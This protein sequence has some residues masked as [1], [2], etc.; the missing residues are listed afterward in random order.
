MKEGSVNLEERLKALQKAYE[1][2][3][4]TI[5]SLPDL[6]P[7]NIKKT[8]KEGVLGDTNLKEFIEDIKNH[9][10]PRFMLIGRTGVGKSSMINALCQSYTAPVSDVSSC[11]KETT[12]YPCKDHG[13]TMIE[14]L[15][16][17]G[18]EESLPIDSQIEAE[19]QLLEDAVEFGPDV[20]ILMLSCTHRDSMDDDITYL[21]RLINEYENINGKDT[22][23]VV[24]V[25]T[26]ADAVPP[27]NQ[28]RPD[29]YSAGK[30]KTL[31]AIEDHVKEVIRSKNLKIENNV[32]TI[33]S[34]IGWADEDGVE[35]SADDINQM[36]EEDRERLTISMDG[37]Y[38]I[39]ELRSLLDSAILDNGARQGFR[40]AFR[41]HAVVESSCSRIINIFSG[42]AGTIALTPI[43]VSDIYLLVVLQALMVVII[44]LLSGRDLTM[45]AAFEFIV[46]LGGIGGVGYALKLLAQQA[47]KFVNAVIPG[48]G[49]VISGLVASAGTY[50]MGK[51]A[52][53][54]YVNDGTVE[55]ARK[56]MNASRKAKE[57]ELDKVRHLE[58]V[59]D[60]DQKKKIKE[61]I[62]KAFSHI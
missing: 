36:K 57:K 41:L 38:H 11:T 14:V 49:S 35:L 60:P 10:P 21:Q 19:K 26:K 28:Y 25:I 27:I 43:P 16:T 56:E 6:V 51:A 18:I 24:V 34:Y 42:I 40:M 15:D 58:K 55:Q 7:D 29:Q 32:V 39:E 5:D 20:A 12:Q 48:A 59:K 54:Y 46:S 47:V 17:R 9:R 62:E 31:K 30:L 33:S 45:D 37:R 3:G 53:A 1:K 52:I 61:E 2:I 23:P 4:E 22:L 44:S 13:R 8:I 50:G